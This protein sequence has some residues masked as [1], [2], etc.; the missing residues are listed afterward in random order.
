MRRKE[1][2][3]WFPPGRLFDSWQLSDGDLNELAKMLG[4][5]PDDETKRQK[6]K[7]GLEALANSYGYDAE[8]EGQP[9]ASWY[10]GELQN[11]VVAAERLSSA[12]ASIQGM[13][14]S[15]LAHRFERS[16]QA[17][18]FEKPVSDQPSLE[19]MLTQLAK[20]CHQ[21]RP[22]DEGLVPGRRPTNATFRAVGSAIELYMNIT[23]S[24]KFPKSFGKDPQTNEFTARPARY[25]RAVFKLIDPHV[26]VA[27]IANNA[28]RHLRPQITSLE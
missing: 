26:T 19:A 27:M 17:K 11:V 10:V 12:L 9:P 21:I 14:R 8:L 7:V 2:D 15:N 1:H 4:V 23:G 13:A 16:F 5:L 24:T 3:K 6:I 18:L 20:A 22:L 25:L 28:R